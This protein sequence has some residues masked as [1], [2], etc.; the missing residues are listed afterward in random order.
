M[1]WL[2]IFLE[3]PLVGFEIKFE[4][5]IQPVKALSLECINTQYYKSTSSQMKFHEF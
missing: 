2:F 3:L 5:L 4:F 1:D